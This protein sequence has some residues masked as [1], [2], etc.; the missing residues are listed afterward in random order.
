MEAT[1]EPVLSSS[2]HLI[3]NTRTDRWGVLGHH[4][5]TSRRRM[6]VSFLRSF[7][8]CPAPGH[9]GDCMP[10]PS[11]EPGSAIYPAHSILQSWAKLYPCSCRSSHKGHPTGVSGTVSNLTSVCAHTGLKTQRWGRVKRGSQPSSIAQKG[12]V[13]SSSSAPLQSP[14]QT[15]WKCCIVSC[16]ALSRGDW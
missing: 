8:S 10:V 2:H 1:S 16:S 11:S 7:A 6:K 9:T 14:G 3:G 5:S 13:H 12:W 15:H 4:S